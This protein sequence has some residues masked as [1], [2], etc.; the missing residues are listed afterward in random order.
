M[1]TRR[2]Q[3]IAKVYLSKWPEKSDTHKTMKAALDR[4]AEL[5]EAGKTADT[6]AWHELTYQDARGIAAE[7]KN[8]DY[9]VRTINKMLSALRGVLECAWRAGKIADEDYRRIEIKNARGKTDPAG[10]ALESA[11][12]DAILAALEG[13]PP[14][15]AALL[16]V[17]CACGLRRIE[18]E[19]LAP[20][21]YD[22][23]TKRLRARG[24]GDKTRTVPV[25]PRW[26]PAIETYLATLEPRARAFPSRRRISYII[27]QFWKE[28]GLREFT[29]HDLRRT[30]ITR[31]IE[32]GDMSIA[33]HLAGHED[34][35][36]TGIYDRRGEAVEDKAV[37]KI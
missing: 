7:L 28:H 9:G 31:V 18:A 22:L 23:K 8:A 4:L 24:K 6:F 32:A 17:L 3:S 19:R 2:T 35:N 30:F 27:E 5:F 20:E 16:A 1:T 11:E 34:M 10:R 21:D 12:T 13:V 33:Q 14:V 29:P 37:E 36:T 26:Q 15:E 25:A